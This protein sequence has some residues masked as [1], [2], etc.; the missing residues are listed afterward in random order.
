M[1]RSRRLG[2]A[3]AAAALLAAAASL[4]VPGPA[5]ASAG[6]PVPG[7]SPSATAAAG[8]STAGRYV[9]R[10]A[11]RHP[12][13]G[14]AAAVAGLGGRVVAVQRSL[15]TAVVELPAGAADRLATRPGVRTVAPD[16]S[17]RATSLG[18]SPATQTGSMTTV[19]R[20]TGANALWRAGWTGAGVD[21][22]LID[23]GVSPVPALSDATKIVVGPDLSFESQDPDLRHLDSYGHGTHMAGIIGGRE[24]AKAGGTTYSGDS[25]NFYGMAPDSRIVS[26]KLADRNGAVDVSQV[27]AAIDWVVQHRSAAGLNIRVLNLSYGTESPQSWTVDPL[28]WAAEVA[29]RDGIVVVTSAGNDGLSGAGLA[30][31]AYNPWLIAVGAVDTKGTDGVDDDVVPAFSAR[32]GGSTG[33]RLL[34][35]V[36][37]G[38]GIVS[39]AVSG[40]HISDANPGARIGNGFIRG[41]GTSQAAAVVS[42]GVALLLQHRPTLTP[43]Q[44]KALLRTSANP[45]PGQPATA[46]G[47]GVLS[48][49]GAMNATPTGSTPTLPQGTGRG[50]LESARAGLH[51]SMDGVELTGELDIM[52][53][54]WDSSQMATLAGNRTAWKGGTFNG[55]EWLGSGFSADTS[56]W[57]GRTWSGRTWSGRTWSGKTWSGKT[58]SGKTWSSATW[59]GAGWSSAAWPSPVSSSGWTTRVWS[60]AGWLSAGW[61]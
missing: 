6:A 58:W 51:L 11:S 46:Q 44:V 49:L 9:V 23:S 13:P 57:A 15:G 18:F 5:A 26:L 55:Q 50:S 54:R 24:T 43:N 3:A 48:L 2:L 20:V 61:S 4:S 25:T 40:S 17:V 60:S 56:S 16:R 21:V 45:I 41:S 1:K 35:V 19:T 29:W 42:G 47:S 30:N 8:A 36:A 7:G 59:N 39:A 38:V 28:S 34:D 27:I 22:A 32:S 37:P 53:Q 12:D 10:L 31:P 14:L 33:D 52:V